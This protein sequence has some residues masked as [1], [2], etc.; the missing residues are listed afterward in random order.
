MDLQERLAAGQP[1]AEA[2][3]AVDPFAEVK[4]RLHLAVIGELGPQLFSEELDEAAMRQ[5]VI[6]SI[7]THLAKEAGISHGDRQAIAADVA[8]DILGHGPLERL[9]ADD[10]ITEIMVNGPHDVWVERAGRLYE[11]PVRFA[12]DQPPAPHHQ[13]DR[14]S[15]RAPH[16]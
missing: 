3:T 13:Q 10:S 2:L 5:K 14:R 15:G 1:S 11:A 9:L 8:D 7:N 4:N 16:R 6:A 12:D